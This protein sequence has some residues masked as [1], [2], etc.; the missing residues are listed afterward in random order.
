[1]LTD[2]GI[3]KEMLQQV[4]TLGS[5]FFDLPDETKAAYDLQQ[6]GAKWRGYM[7]MGGERSISGKVKDNKEGLYMGDEHHTDH[8]RLGLPTFG[9]NVFP[10]EVPGMA[11]LFLG[12]HLQMKELGN[13]VMGILSEALGLPSKDYIE[14]HVTCHDPVILPRMFR[15]PPQT[16][17][18]ET[19]SGIGRHSDY[20]LWTMILSD[21]PGLEFQHPKTGE[22]H[23]VPHIPNS[24]IMNVGDVLDRLTSGRFV[25][26]YH[27][28]SNLSFDRPR[29][30]LPFF[31]DPSWDAKMLALPI[32]NTD[33]Y[34]TLE[35]EDRW[36]RT[37]ITCAFD[38]SVAYSEFLAK[39][40]AKVFPDLV[41]E[42]LWRR[43]PGTASP[44]TRH[45]LVVG[46]P[47]ERYT[48]V[49]ARLVQQFY[50]DHPEIKP[51]H[52]WAHVSAVL[53]HATAAVAAASQRPGGAP[54]DSQTCMEIKAAALLHDVDDRKYFP[55]HTQY[56]NAR[57]VLAAAGVP[58]ES[59]AA[60][61]EMIALVSCSANGNR[62]P[63][64]IAAAGA[65]HRLIPRWADRLEAVGE[66]GVVRC[67]RYNQE[68]GRPLSGPGSPRPTTEEELWRYA[69]PER[70]EAYLESGESEDM[71][72]HYYDKLLHVARPPEGIVCNAYL[73]K[74]AE[75]SSAPLVE[76]LLRFGR[77]GAVDEEFIEELARKCM[78]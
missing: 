28:A 35:R 26:A 2:H 30:S 50:R 29:L 66:V 12:Y 37:K 57:T 76:L 44:S 60:V 6:Y 5:A 25:S 15:Y 55:Q 61:V 54:L 67:Y 48:P 70:F 3:D 8:P 23:A 27:R 58:P 33:L 7:R 21:S 64:H 19:K 53:G 56:E 32:K 71:V 40:V 68:V 10:A 73:E 18:E 45:A 59:A 69:T 24:L 63:D 77:T 16:R 17:G 65:W 41:P 38:G 72:A 74:A 52:G 42:A 36:A 75:E 9:Q 51:S 14:T 22:W 13:E 47:D 4:L 49:L 31:Y 39:K 11:E 34:A 78:R 1:M 46:A 20:G 43:L 62:V